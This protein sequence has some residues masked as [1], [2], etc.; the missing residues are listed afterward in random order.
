MWS[1]Y[2]DS[3]KGVCLTVEV[4]SSLIYPVCYTSKRLQK[5][6]DINKLLKNGKFKNKKSIPANYDSLSNLKK[7]AYIKD[8]KWSDERE[9]RIVFNDNED[10]LIRENGKTFMSVKIKNIY[11]GANFN[12]NDNGIQ[13]AI[14]EACKKKNISIKQMVLSDTDYSLKIQEYNYGSI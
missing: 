8:S 3:H 1:H 9:Y 14:V 12:K 6:S 4:P 11:L 13:K 5:N 10:G 2:G 7:Q